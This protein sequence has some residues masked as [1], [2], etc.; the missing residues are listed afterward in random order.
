MNPTVAFI[1]KSQ[2]D[3]LSRVA[4]CLWRVYD[5]PHDY[6]DGYIVRKFEVK[7]GEQA[8]T[9]ETLRTPDEAGLDLLRDAFQQAGLMCMPRREGDDLQFIETWV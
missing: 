4:I 1:L 9:K 6:P 5:H 8:A 2:Q 3:S 7:G